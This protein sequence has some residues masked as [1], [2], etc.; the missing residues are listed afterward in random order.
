MSMNRG[1][2]SARFALLLATVFSFG[3]CR[4]DERAAADPDRPAAPSAPDQARIGRLI[5]EKL[6]A[7]LLAYMERLQDVNSL[8]ADTLA[9][10]MPIHRRMLEDVL[11][12]AEREMANLD[13]PGV[14]RWR[15]LTDSLRRDLPLTERLRGEELRAFLTAHQMR[16]QRMIDLHATMMAPVDSLTSTD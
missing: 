11:E 9:A 3:G 4:D 5:G 14:T 12:Q 6:R 13:V 2:R 15:A 1:L 16:V 10:R 7:D 8:S